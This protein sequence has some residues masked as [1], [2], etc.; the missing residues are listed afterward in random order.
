MLLRLLLGFGLAA[1]APARLTVFLVFLATHRLDIV[2]YVLLLYQI[3]KLVNGT[4][5]NAMRCDGMKWN[6]MRLRA[7]DFYSKNRLDFI[8]V[9]CI[10]DTIAS[11][12]NL[13]DNGNVHI[14]FLR[15]FFLGE[16]LV[17]SRLA[18]SIAGGFR[19]I[20][21]LFREVISVAATA[22]AAGIGTGSG[23]DGRGGVHV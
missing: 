14:A 7:W 8:H 5:W 4:E 15:E 3:F 11:T 19:D 23:H 20:L 2:E 10:V 21:G 17:A 18:D 1:A 13:C 6:G 12:F 9:R 22:T 16:F